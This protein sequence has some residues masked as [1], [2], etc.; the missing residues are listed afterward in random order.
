MKQWRRWWLWLC[1]SFIF[2]FLF[3][4]SCTFSCFVDNIIGERKRLPSIIMFPS[5]PH[6]ATQR[7]VSSPC[8]LIPASTVS[9]TSG[10]MAMAWLAANR[11]RFVNMRIKSYELLFVCTL[12]A[13]VYRYWWCSWVH[14]THFYI[15]LDPWCVHLL[16]SI[17]RQWLQTFLLQLYCHLLHCSA[18]WIAHCS[19]TYLFAVF[20]FTAICSEVFKCSKPIQ[21]YI[22]IP[23]VSPYCFH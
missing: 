8:I 20:H 17:W 15:H 14:G 7:L 18:K 5:V 2:L 22:S 1:E 4:G 23:N 6:P 12:N 13:S 16:H 3:F 10:W 19:Y 9:M 11:L 21:A